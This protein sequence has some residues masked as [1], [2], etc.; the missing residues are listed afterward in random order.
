MWK[1]AIRSLCYLIPHRKNQKSLISNKIIEFQVKFKIVLNITF[2]KK[3]NFLAEPLSSLRWTPGFLKASSGEHRIIIWQAR[4]R[5][6]PKPVHMAFTDT[7]WHLGNF[8]IV[9]PCP[10][11]FTN[12]PYW[13]IRNRRHNV[14]NW[15]G[16]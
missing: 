6:N 13:F 11:H 5:F 2:M 16:N 4:P 15:H 1:K 14:N 9:F 7:K 3:Q 12:D 8:L 10:Y